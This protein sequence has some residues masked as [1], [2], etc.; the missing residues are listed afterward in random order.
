MARHSRA[1]SQSSKFSVLPGLSPTHSVAGTRF[2]RSGL[3]P[4]ER[5]QAGQGVLLSEHLGVRPATG[6]YSPQADRRTYRDQPWTARS[7]A[8]RDND[9]VSLE[10]S[11]A[12]ADS[13]SSHHPP[14]HDRKPWEGQRSGDGFPRSDGSASTAGSSV[15]RTSR[16]SAR[17]AELQ[18][19]LATCDSQ[20]SA[21]RAEVDAIRQQQGQASVAP[22]EQLQQ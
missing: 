5:F 13:L 8:S 21:M 18:N 2:A 11:S 12:S 6:G 17:E 3:S 7:V 9:D 16:T 10:V 20:L 1:T 19:Q 15:S 22:F 4:V 14:S